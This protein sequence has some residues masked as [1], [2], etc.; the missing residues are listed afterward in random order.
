MNMNLTIDVKALELSIDILARKVPVSSHSTVS[1]AGNAIYKESQLLVPVDT[2]A[3]KRSGY[4][5]TT[6]KQGS[7]TVKVG[8]SDAKST[9]YNP[10][11]GKATSEYATVVHED[12]TANHP[13]GSAR[14]LALA[15]DRWV[16]TEGLNGLSKQLIEDLGL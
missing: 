8:Y 3:L 13:L 5:R 7:S 6:T 16:S 12:T 14:F 15:V 10:K 4:H 11:T 1:K 2:K 9:R